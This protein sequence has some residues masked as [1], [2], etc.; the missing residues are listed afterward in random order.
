MNTLKRFVEMNS[1]TDLSDVNIF[2]INHSFSREFPMIGDKEVESLSENF[3]LPFKKCFVDFKKSYVFQFQDVGISTTIDNLMVEEVSPTDIKVTV[4]YRSFNGLREAYGYKEIEYHDG[5]AVTD[6]DRFNTFREYRTLA[7]LSNVVIKILEE[8]DSRKYIYVENT[9]KIDVKFRDKATR[10]LNRVK[11]TPKMII[12]VSD[13]KT[14]KK[15]YP[16]LSGRVISKPQHAFEV[17]GHWRRLHNENS[18]GKNR[19]GEYLVEGFTWVRPQVRCAD[20][21]E[22]LKKVRVIQ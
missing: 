9:E 17:M 10:K 12:Y 20:R 1:I 15:E 11:Y 5:K 3:G 16:E 22:V 2:K 6:L 13:K 8:L 4:G 21:G 7:T 18:L 19:E 14:F